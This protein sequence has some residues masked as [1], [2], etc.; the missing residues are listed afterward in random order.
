MTMNG[1]RITV[2]GARQRTMIALLLLNPGRIVSVDTLVETVWNGQPPATART[3]VAIC[4]AALRK[5]FKAEGC[6]NEVI[7]TA[8]PGYVLDLENHYVDSVDFDRLAGEA[9]EAARE[10][11]TAD[12]AHLYEQA[13]A[14]WRGPALAGVAGMLVEEESARLEEVRLATYDGYV[15]AQLELGHHRDLIP[16]LVTVVRDHPLRERSRHALMLAQYR[17]GRRAEA[18]ET[19]RTGRA[20]FI[21]QLGLEPGPDLQELHDAILR[22]DPS[23]AAPPAAAAPQQPEAAPRV[24]PAELPADVAHFTGRAAQLEALDALLRP[25]GDHLSPAVAL[26]TG[27][28]G[29]GKTGLAVHWAHRAAGHFP[30]G[31]LFADLGE[32]GAAPGTVPAD[33]VLSRFLRSLGVPAADVPGDAEGRVAL[34]RSVLADRRVLIVLD[35]VRAFAPI[36]ALIPGGSRCGV[37]VT[38]RGQLEEL[39]VGHGAVPVH[40]EALTKPEATELL[41]HVIGAQ[42][43]D[44]ARPEA[45]RLVELCDRLPLTVRIAAARLAS[46]PHW[47]VGHLAGR[48]ADERLRLDALSSGESQLRDCFARSYGALEP[49]AALLFRRLALLD[50]P[51]FT[52]WVGA[53]LLD[54]DTFTA[55]GLMERLADARLLQ[56]AGFDATGRP[57]YRFQNLLRL[58]A[59][60]LAEQEAAQGDAAGQREAVERALESWLTIAEHAR[61]REFGREHVLVRGDTPRR[62]MDPAEL[63][64][65]TTSPLDWFEAERLALISVIDQAARRGMT[66]LSRDLT[67]LVV[68]PFETCAFMGS[69]S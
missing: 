51:D 7:V 37:V 58:Y 13:L 21:E 36:R 30:D 66:D 5:R 10:G 69:L 25:Q 41:G 54:V 60:E 61:R 40:L 33:A 68:G 32:S 55:E 11:R 12:A 1:R 53:A 52:C 38:S 45:E 31:L 23:L 14:L 3:Q 8:H 19:F 62:P 2:G 16:G 4:I 42:R 15:A 43:V 35:D 49:T 46:K 17:V 24:L 28:A 47:P 44:A 22:D 39:V 26:I 48:L 20:Q 65:L 29:V 67:V 6:E 18:M 9:Q 64:Q 56:V 50:V 59:R 57:R 63:D 27:P 34:F